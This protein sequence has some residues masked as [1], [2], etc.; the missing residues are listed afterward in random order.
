MRILEDRNYLIWVV[1]AMDR[2]GGFARQLGQAAL[3]ADKENLRKLVLAFPEYFFQ[4]K[5]IRLVYERNN[6]LLE[7]QRQTGEGRGI[8]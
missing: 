8:R 5:A 6:N 3:L 4:H 7:G 2:M 1:E